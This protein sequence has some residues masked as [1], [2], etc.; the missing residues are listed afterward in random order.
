MA[1]VAVVWYLR[2]ETWRMVLPLIL[3]SLGMLL[4]AFNCA[5]SL[6]LMLRQ[7]V[8]SENFYVYLLNIV[9]NGA[10]LVYFFYQMTSYPG[11]RT[12]FLFEWFTNGTHHL[13]D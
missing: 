3:M 4:W 2:L 12:Q 9:F 7:S 13:L 6:V 10:P 5:S 8:K 11:P 1:S